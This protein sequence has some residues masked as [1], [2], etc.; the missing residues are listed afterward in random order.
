M[1]RPFNENGLLIDDISERVNHELVCDAISLSKCHG[2]IFDG[3]EYPLNKGV[4]KCR[5]YN[6]ASA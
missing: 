4:E 6:L 1:G 3:G 5:C 2:L